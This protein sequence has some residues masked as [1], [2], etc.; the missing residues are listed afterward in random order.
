V[1]YFE[2]MVKDNQKRILMVGAKVQLQVA[3]AFGWK[4]AGGGMGN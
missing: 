2:K 4:E 3:G 1:I